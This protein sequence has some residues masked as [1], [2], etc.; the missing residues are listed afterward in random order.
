MK[1]CFWQLSRSIPLMTMVFVN[2]G[3]G[4]QVERAAGTIQGS[5]EWSGTWPDSNNMLVALFAISPWRS[6]FHPGPPAA[7]RMINQPAQQQVQFS[8]EQPQVAFGDYQTLVIAWRDPDD[9]NP[10]TQ[11][12]MV[13]V[14]G[15]TLDQLQL[16][17]PIVLDKLHPDATGLVMSPMIL[18]Q[19]NGDMR[20]HYPSLGG[21]G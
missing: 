21:G 13:S 11:M 14:Y 15:T 8:I 7:F 18:Y 17:K 2:A 3:C 16:A 19:N 6:D 9:S 5:V 1:Q 12:R 10:A 4:N 20:N